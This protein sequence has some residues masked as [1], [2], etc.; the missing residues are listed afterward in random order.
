VFGIVS[1]ATVVGAAGVA[2][3]AAASVLFALA[4]AMLAASA[5]YVL[6]EPAS[7]VVDVTPTRAG[8]RT[9]ARALGLLVPLVVGSAL[10]GAGAVRGIGLP[11]PAVSLALVASVVL[12]FTVSC[13]ARTRTGEPGSGAATAVVLAL[14]GP[15]LLPIVAGYV[16]TFPAST[17]DALPSERLWWTVLAV[18]DVAIM[19]TLLGPIT[20]VR[21]SAAERAPLRS[22]DG[23]EHRLD[24][25]HQP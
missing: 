16:H 3:P 18:C 17:A 10:V 13:I 2:V 8:V 25:G 9:A 22:R 5:A 7:P 6:D 19:S 24:H 1:A 23:R 21:P 20:L 4:F 15:S 12:G 14:T 11:W